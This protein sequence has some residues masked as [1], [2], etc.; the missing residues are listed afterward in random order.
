M[1]IKPTEINEFTEKT[2]QVVWDNGEENIFF[3]EELR[4]ICPCAKCRRLRKKS[5]TGKLPFKKRIPLGKDGL[6]PE[7]IE[8]VGNYAIRF[9]GQNWCETGF[10]TFDFLRK[11]HVIDK[12]L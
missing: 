7:R 6:K 4:E 9:I 3:Y 11:N 1:G 8:F 12:K 10:Y 2:L 5:R